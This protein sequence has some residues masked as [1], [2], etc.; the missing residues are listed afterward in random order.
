MSN[1]RV[2]STVYKLPTQ[3]QLN[4]DDDLIVLGDTS[5]VVQVTDP[6][7]KRVDVG[8]SAVSGATLSVK[9]KP[10]LIL[11]KYRVTYRVI[12]AD[13]HPVSGTYPFYLAKKPTKK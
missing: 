6:K 10:S 1:P 2:G 5:D 7:G 3:V 11:G 8:L 13:G 12:S 4:F 9:L